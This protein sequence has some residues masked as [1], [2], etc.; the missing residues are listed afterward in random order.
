MKIIR[1]HQSSLQRQIH[2]AVLLMFSKADIIMNSKTEWN[3]AKIPRIMI[4]VGDEQEEDAEVQEVREKVNTREGDEVKTLTGNVCPPQWEGDIP[5]EE[6]S[7]VELE[8]E[9]EEKKD[10]N[11]EMAKKRDVVRFDDWPHVIRLLDVVGFDEWPN[12]VGL[13]DVAGFDDWPHVV[14]LFLC[15]TQRV[16]VVYF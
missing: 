16:A 11:E 5:V 13:L 15:S 12:V 4:E 6:S 2:E 1:R 10:A 8:G 14:G 7:S 3:G 9:V